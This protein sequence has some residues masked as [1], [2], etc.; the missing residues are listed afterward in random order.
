LCPKKPFAGT[1]Y[2]SGGPPLVR[3]ATGYMGGQGTTSPTA[4]IDI[5]DIRGKKAL[6]PDGHMGIQG[7]REGHKE[8]P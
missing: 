3:I 7:H 1:T 8:V 5:Q 6:G 2:W 4:E